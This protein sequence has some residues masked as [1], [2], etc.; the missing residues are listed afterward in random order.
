MRVSS[1]RYSNY[2]LVMNVF[3]CDALR[4][5]LLTNFLILYGNSM[6]MYVI[7]K[8]IMFELLVFGIHLDARETNIEGNKHARN[9]YIYIRTLYHLIV[10]AN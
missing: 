1:A 8:V 2:R 7:W 4:N 5:F 10:Q 3:E 9:W 6:K